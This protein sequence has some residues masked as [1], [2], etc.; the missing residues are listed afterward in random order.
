MA[1]V[2]PRSREVPLRPRFPAPDPARKVGLEAAG[3]RR[4]RAS[5][6]GGEAGREEE[7]GGEGA[8]G[9]GAPSVCH[10]RSPS[11]YRGC[12]EWCASRRRRRRSST[13]Q[14]LA[15][16]AARLGF[17]SP[18]EAPQPPQAPDPASRPGHGPAPGPRAPRLLSRAG[19]G[20]EAGRPGEA[21]AGAESSASRAEKGAR[22]PRPVPAALARAAR[23]P[24][25]P[26]WPGLS[27]ECTLCNSS[28][29]A[30]PTASRRA[31]NS[32]SGMM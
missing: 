28:P 7:G 11:V 14:Q 9:G 6:G 30:C 19:G 18:S 4:D 10:S 24:D 1:A 5:E 29:C 25:E 3:G 17:P 22:A 13:R 21:S 31:P 27:P 16:S 2:G 26:R 20:A 8:G 23:S 12:A 15:A 32:S